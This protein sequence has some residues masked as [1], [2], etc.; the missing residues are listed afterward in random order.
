MNHRILSIALVLAFVVRSGATPIPS[1]PHLEKHGQA[2]QLMVQDQPFLA[3]AGEVY[4][5]SS[6]SRE[7]MGGIWPRLAAMHINTVL[8][9]VS[10]EQLEPKEGQFDFTLLDGLI[11][12]ARLN[13]MHLILLWFASWKNM[14][15]SYAPEWLRDNPTRFPL[16]VDKSGNRLPIPSTFSATGQKADARAFAALMKHLRTMDGEKQTVIMIQVENEVGVPD[17]RDHSDLAKI[18]R[19]ASPVPAEL[20]GLFGEAAQMHSPPK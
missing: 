13:H 20:S 14:V 19:N 18:K 17:D 10:W 11:A 6:S 12:D 3:L 9:P 15:S 4:N 2:I 7:Y 1:A 16:V 8:T 5:S